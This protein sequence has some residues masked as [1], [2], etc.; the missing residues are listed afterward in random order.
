MS[1]AEYDYQIWRKNLHEIQLKIDAFD[2]RFVEQTIDIVD[3]A[4]YNKRKVGNDKGRALLVEELE[5]H[6]QSEPRY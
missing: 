6:Y 1:L 5:R 3:D 2:L 4:V